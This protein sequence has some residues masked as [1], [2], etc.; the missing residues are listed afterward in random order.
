MRYVLPDDN[1]TTNFTVAKWFILTVK[2]ANDASKSP[3]HIDIYVYISHPHCAYEMGLLSQLYDRRSA[4]LLLREYT[5]KDR[6]WFDLQN[7]Y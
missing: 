4:L 1:V 3:H 6:I 5:S 7:E 2:V